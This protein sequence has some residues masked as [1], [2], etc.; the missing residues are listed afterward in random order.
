MSMKDLLSEFINY[1]A[2]ERRLAK[3]TV[4]AYSR[5]INRFISLM[6]LVSSQE[7]L[8]ITR[9]D[10]SDYLSSFKKESL[11]AS[12]QARH[13]VSMKMFFRFLLG[14]GIIDSDPTEH[15]ESPALTRKLPETLSFEEVEQLLKMP[16]TNYPLGFRDSAMIEL[17]YATGVR[18]SELIS[19]TLNDINL[20]VGYIISFGKGSKER[21]IPLGEEASLKLQ[22]YLSS[23][24]PLIIKDKENKELFVNRQGN[25]MTRQGFWKIIK[26]YTRTAGIVKKIS[27]HSLRHS[28]A[29]HLLEGGADLRSVQKMLGHA[30]IS[31]TQIYTHIIKERLRSIYDK[32]HPRA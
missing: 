11:S 13:L 24:R 14:E 18:V 7:V 12:S 2:V 6:K 15:I 16:D 9:T 8:K 32:Y 3:N 29:T 10:I 25:K 5:D 4:D 23:S 22:G 31:T 28:F 1:L 17:L 21:I 26:K 30:D 20:E 27:P 19:L